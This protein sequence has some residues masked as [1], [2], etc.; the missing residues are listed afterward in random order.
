MQ[1]DAWTKDAIVQ[2]LDA[3]YQS[4]VRVCAR[5]DDVGAH[6]RSGIWA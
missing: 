6:S 3:H 4:G 5:L 2:L 1:L